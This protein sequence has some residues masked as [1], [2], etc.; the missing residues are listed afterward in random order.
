MK[1]TMGIASTDVDVCSATKGMLEMVFLH[2]ESPASEKF[3]I[4][5]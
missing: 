2:Q 3:V 4:D 5:V 1:N